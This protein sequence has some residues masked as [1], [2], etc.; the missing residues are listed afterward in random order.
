MVQKGAGIPADDT[1]GERQL[2][3]RRLPAT[4]RIPRILDAALAEFSARGFALTR[5]DDIA[6]RAGLSKGGIYL[7]FKSKEYLLEALLHHFLDPFSIEDWEEQERSVTPDL[8]VELLGRAY[9]RLT[10]EPAINAIRLVI[11][12]GQRVSAI[13]LLWQ[14]YLEETVNPAMQRLISA[15]IAQG[16]IRSGIVATRPD[17]LFAPIVLT[18]MRYLIDNSQRPSPDEQV[19]DR[20]SCEAMQRELLTP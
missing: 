7:H 19:R 6:A 5:M 18:G 10:S 20:A 12:E 1:D 15:G 9:D 2:S 16:T 3:R 14:R 4:V 17:L 13:V 8:I 11:A